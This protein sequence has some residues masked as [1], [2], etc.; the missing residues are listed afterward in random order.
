MAD[1]LR[2]GY[3]ML[4]IACPVCNNPVFRNKEGEKFCPSCNRKVVVINDQATQNFEKR[5]ITSEN[6]L[7]NAVIR[8]KDVLNSLN[9]VILKKMR[10]LI[11]KLTNE[12]QLELIKNYTNILSNLYDLLNKITS[13]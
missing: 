4:N 6:N 12:T 11:E 1:L 5:V 13:S 2:S 10:F 8:N 9:E 7:N 3:T